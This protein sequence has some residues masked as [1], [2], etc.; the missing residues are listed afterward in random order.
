[1]CNRH[2]VWINRFEL[3]VGIFVAAE[4]LE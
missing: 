2:E 1:V 3:V 4:H